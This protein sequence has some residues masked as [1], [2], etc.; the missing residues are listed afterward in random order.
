MHGDNG[1]TERKNAACGGQ[2]FGQ[3]GCGALGWRKP[4]I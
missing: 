4:A 3:T 1:E 2:R